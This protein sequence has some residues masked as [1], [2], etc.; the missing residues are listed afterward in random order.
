LSGATSP[1][2]KY[3][4]FSKPILIFPPSLTA[5]FKHS[6]SSFSKAHIAQSDLNLFFSNLSK[7]N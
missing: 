7:Y 6:N 3:K 2:G 1:D 5:S 4:E